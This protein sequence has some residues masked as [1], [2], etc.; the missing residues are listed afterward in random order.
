MQ[1][2]F[3]FDLKSW[4]RYAWSQTSG[5]IAYW[6]ILRGILPL[7]LLGSMGWAQPIGDKSGLFSSP[8]DLDLFLAGNYGE[9]RMGHFH[10]GLDLKTESRENHPVYAAAEGYVS[11]IRIQ[12]GG[13]GHALYIDHPS[14]YTTVYA[15]LNDFAAPLQAY[16]RQQQYEREA[17][18][19][20]LYPEPGQFPVERREFIAY[21][22]NT[23]ASQA[24]HLHF[25]IRDT[26]S[27][28]P[29]NPLLFG[30][31]IKDR[32]PPVPRRLLLYDM[33][34]PFY[35]QTRRS[36]AL[37]GQQGRYRPSEG[38]TLTVSSGSLGI[39]VE[40]NDFMDG[41][42]NTLNFLQASVF[43]NGEEVQQIYLDSIGFHETRYLHAY[44]DYLE[45]Y[46]NNRWVQL[47]FPLPGNGL[48]QI[49][50]SHYPRGP[51]KLPAGTS[52]LRMVFKDAFGN[53]S[54]IQCWIRRV[55]RPAAQPCARPHAWDQAFDFHIPQLR[56]Q[57]PAG[58]VY[59]DLCIR[60]N[61]QAS[62][63]RG[64]SS[65]FQVH[66]AEV[67]IHTYF[68]LE[69]QPPVPIPFELRPKIILAYEDKGRKRYYPAK[70]NQG[71]YGAS[72]RDFGTYWL[73]L[74]TTAPT[75]HPL[76][77]QGA[78]LS[79]SATLRFRV[80]DDKVGIASFRVLL[81]GQWLLFEGRGREYVYTFDEYCPQGNHELEVEAVDFMGNTKTIKYRF[82]R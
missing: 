65:V 16:L 57:M 18:E 64:I 15:H 41:S 69:I 37:V 26:R 60:V 7:L 32:V 43:L 62:R 50:A 52:S 36:Y 21:S 10:A 42:Q 5:R 29:L 61:K 27:E 8:L 35:D 31:P 71:W 20:D 45:E 4:F 28:H 81:Q 40:V 23:G 19:V 39:G 25:E 46:R 79:R 53:P 11:R 66:R 34:L 70:F 38:D 48:Q 59:D 51:I 30:L 14:G 56:F 76:A 49:Y 1:Q 6:G 55:D 22:G 78:D 75:I 67:P 77:P 72:I 73:D 54:E 58:S 74:D 63:T 17:W 12:R 33:D 2:R 47:L 80:E 44:V 9:C 82:K 68:P 24:P 3:F 13:Y